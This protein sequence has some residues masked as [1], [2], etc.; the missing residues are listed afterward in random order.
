MGINKKDEELLEELT[1]FS[2]P[3]WF[4][5]NMHNKLHLDE[6]YFPNKNKIL[7]RLNYLQNC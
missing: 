2:S 5:G 3:E 6:A 1:D 7:N 4:I